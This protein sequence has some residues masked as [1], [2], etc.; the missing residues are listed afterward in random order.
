M[1]GMS[2]GGIAPALRGGA[3][4][5]LAH[6]G[7]PRA[8]GIRGSACVVAATLATFVA[9]EPAS[10][11]VLQGPMPFSVDAQ[12]QA[13]DAIAPDVIARIGVSVLRGTRPHCSHGECTSTSCDGIGTVQLEFPELRDDRTPAARMGVLLEVVQGQ[14]PPGLM[15]AWPLQPGA[16]GTLALTWGDKEDAIEQPIDFMIVAR[17]L[18]AAG[19]AGPASE[20]VRIH[21]DGTTSE[22]G[23]ASEQGQPSCTTTAG[24]G[25][26]V[27][28]FLASA[29]LLLATAAV[30]WRVRQRSALL[31]VRR[32]ASRARR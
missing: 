3:I 4:S 2:D 21:H 20:P 15:P 17:A 9:A 30:I 8:L 22:D 7:V 23:I 10:A 29:L 5:M 13:V 11:C 27:S 6:A 25:R 18:D 19:N 26:T 24:A 14:A 16:A 32:T 28:S 1:R 12:A 31:L